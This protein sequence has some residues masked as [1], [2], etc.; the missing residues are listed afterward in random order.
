MVKGKYNQIRKSRKISI[1]M[2]KKKGRIENIIEFNI[3][4]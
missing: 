4:F 1:E 3:D 2:N